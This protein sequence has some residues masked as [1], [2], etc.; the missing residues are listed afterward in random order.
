MRAA[1]LVLL[2]PRSGA[3]R[4]EKQ[5]PPK[6]G[7]RRLE[8]TDDS[9][10]NARDGG[11]IC[12]TIH[13]DL[14]AKTTDD[15]FSPRW[16][17]RLTSSSRHRHTHTHTHTH[18][19]TQTH[20]PCDHAH[21]RASSVAMFHCPLRAGNGIAGHIDDSTPARLLP[22]L[23][24][25]GSRHGGKVC[26]CVVR[27][28]IES[29]I[30]RWMASY[31]SRSASLPLPLPLPLS[32]QRSS[33]PAAQQ[34]RASSQRLCRIDAAATGAQRVPGRGRGGPRRVVPA[35]PAEPAAPAHATPTGRPIPTSTT[36]LHACNGHLAANPTSCLR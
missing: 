17:S 13:T 18:R 21:G 12:G 30:G 11:V 14:P 3:G 35:E 5:N 4:S 29:I 20:A 16:R 26:V 7:S 15:T 8:W 32:H 23:Q 1:R 6:H 25:V 2:S 28:V 10:A 27:Q 19:Q 36:G 31:P 33:S 22:L 34:P 24:W 9:R